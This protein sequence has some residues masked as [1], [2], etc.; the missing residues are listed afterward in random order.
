MKAPMAI[1][2]NRTSKIIPENAIMN[3]ILILFLITND[4][5]SV[6]NLQAAKPIPTRA[7]I[8]RMTKMISNMYFS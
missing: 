8:I 1:M 5:F 4:F 6:D 2:I 7:A 3:S